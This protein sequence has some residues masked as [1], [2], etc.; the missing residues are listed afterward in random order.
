MAKANKAQER[1]Q[2]LIGCTVLSILGLLLLGL[3]YWGVRALTSSDSKVMPDF[4]G[5][6][7]EIRWHAYRVDSLLSL[8]RPTEQLSLASNTGLGQTQ[9][10]SLGNLRETFCDLND[11]Q[12]ATAEVLGIPPLN[13]RAELEG[14]RTEL[15]DISDIEHTALLQPMVHSVPLLV[16]RAAR[17]LEHIAR[18]FR[19]ALVQKGLEPHALVVTSVLRSEEDIRKLR[20]S[21]GNASANSCHRYGTTFDV[22][23]KRFRNSSTGEDVYD[24]RFKQVLAEVLHDYRQLGACYVVYERRQACFHLTA[25]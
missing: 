6:A 2:R 12:L 20:K 8:P 14:L 24:D 15:V 4:S 9:A 11:V 7:G 5:A 10:P 22:S 3:I 18:S 21:N 25:R 1:R 13:T 23:W 16:P 17:L 19:D